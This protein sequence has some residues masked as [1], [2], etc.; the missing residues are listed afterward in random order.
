[1]E[2][3][4]IRAVT[5]LHKVVTGIFLLFFLGSAALVHGGDPYSAYYSAAHN[6]LFWF[7]QISDIHIGAAEIQ[8]SANLT[9]IIT[10]GKSIINPEFI[11]ASGD[12]TDSTNGDGIIP[13][14]PHIE[15]WKEYAGILAGAQGVN[16]I[17]FFDI[18]GNHD[19][20]NDKSFAYYLNF[21][22][23]GRF[24]QFAGSTQVS[25]RKDF[26]FGRYHFIGI[27]T[28]GNDGARFSLFPWDFY[29]DHAGLDP[30]EL[31]FIEN[32]LQENADAD[33]TVIF[34]HHPLRPTGEATDTYLTYGL[35]EF[36]GLMETYGVSLYAY[37]HTHQFKKELLPTN[38]SD[39][40]FYLNTSSL[41]KAASD[42]YTII[43]IDC[44]GIST[45]AQNVNT[46]PTVLITAPLDMHYGADINPYAYP[47]GS[48]NPKPVRALV[49]DKNPV[50][51]VKFRLDASPNWQSM[52]QVPG[53]SH[54]WEG[55]WQDTAMTAGQH[56]LE[57]QAVGSSTRSH[58]ITILDA[59]DISDVIA[60]LQVSAG[61]APA[62]AV[63]QDKDINGDAKIGLAEAVYLLQKVSGRR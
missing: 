3:V 9:W 31:S 53:N 58:V 50:T 30:G 22:I 33:I 28:A 32:K 60:V 51:Q 34:G 56:T 48:V 6:R 41:G 26:P 25:W 18:P 21:S 17:N 49:F 19:H 23:Q 12:L 40:V 54:L 35:E 15:E 1:M 63:N 10:E 8:D 44:N 20:Y 4:G 39:G 55:Y 13:D 5:I 38:H 59:Y 16:E 29:G 36:K 47:V 24:G 27:N 2:S 37:G 46:W 43:A 7:I 61:M 57:V 11:V 45:I 52:T 62:I 42:Q 14:G